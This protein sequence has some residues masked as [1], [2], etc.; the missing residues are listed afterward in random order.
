MPK[1]KLNAPRFAAGGV[2]GVHAQRDVPVPGVE[3]GEGGFLA[4]PHQVEQRCVGQ[5]G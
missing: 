2:N 1:M 5:S 3:L 4:I